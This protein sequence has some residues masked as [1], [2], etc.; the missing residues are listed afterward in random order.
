MAH[1]SNP[2]NSNLKIYFYRLKERNK[3][4]CLKETK[5]DPQT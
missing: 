1:G 2:V 4:K 5:H 3:E